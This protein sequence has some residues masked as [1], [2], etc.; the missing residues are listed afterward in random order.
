MVID[1]G[2]HAEHLDGAHTRA[3]SS[4]DVGVEDRASR[5]SDVVG[6]DLSDEL[7]DVDARRAGEDTRSVVAIEA[8]RSF[9]LGLSFGVER[10]AVVEGDFR[11]RLREA[12]VGAAEAMRC[13]GH[14]LAPPE[15]GHLFYQLRSP[16]ARVGSTW[17][18]GAES[19]K[20]QK[21]LKN[22]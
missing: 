9:R 1:A 7:R 13:L 12:R 21:R 22:F 14:S 19:R 5:A 3:R 8:A 16:Y 2:A 10:L 17:A 6:R 4:Q 18:K 15:Q 11:A 20:D